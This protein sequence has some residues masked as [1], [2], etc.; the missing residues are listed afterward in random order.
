[1]GHFGV[2]ANPDERGYLLDLQANLLA[3][4]NTRVVVPLMPLDHSPTPAAG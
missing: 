2:H 1:M 4:Y 3:D